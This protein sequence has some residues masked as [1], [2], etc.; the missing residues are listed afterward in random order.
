METQIL[1]GESNVP[2]VAWY[3]WVM[4]SWFP[5]VE[6]CKAN[7]QTWGWKVT[8]ENLPFCEE[9]STSHHFES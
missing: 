2:E 8:L 3:F 1:A 6:I 7:L 9:F 5:L 4:G